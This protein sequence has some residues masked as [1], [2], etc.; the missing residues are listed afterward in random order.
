M[1]KTISTE[2]ARSKLD[3]IVATVQEA[4]QAVVLVQNGKPVAAVVNVDE[5]ERYRQE[6]IKRGW[7]TIDRVRE[8]NAHLDPDEV[9]R[10]VTEIVEEVRQEMY[11][12]R[13]RAAEGQR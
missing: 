9:L 13:Q 6:R 10:E 8:R 5:Y 3:D 2:D 4:H 12:E 1:V 7:E 11:E